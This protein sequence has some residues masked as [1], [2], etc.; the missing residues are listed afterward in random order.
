MSAIYT[1]PS[2]FT[3]YLLFD[4]PST[5]E[6][7]KASDFLNITQIVTEIELKASEPVPYSSLANNIVFKNAEYSVRNTFYSTTPNA[8]IYT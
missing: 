4:T 2:T 7:L 5:N 1:F 3:H 6:K 8:H